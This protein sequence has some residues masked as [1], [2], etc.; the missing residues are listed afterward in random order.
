MLGTRENPFL[1]CEARLCMKMARLLTVLLL[2]ATASSLSVALTKTTTTIASSQNPSIYEQPVTFTA[3]VSPVPPNGE[4]VTFKQGANVLGTGPLSSGSATFTISTLTTGGTDNITAVYGGDSTYATSTSTAVKQVVDPIPTSTSVAS[5]L[6]PSTYGQAV[7]FT[8]SVSS[9]GSGTITG[10]VGFYNGS[11]S[12]GTGAVSGG[13]ASYKTTKLQLPAG[14]DSITAVYKGSTTF[15]TSTSGV[16]SQKVTSTGGAIPTTTTLT[17]SQNPSSYGQTVS[18]TAAVAAGGEPLPASA[19]GDTVTFKQGS[20]TIG[21]GKLSGGSATFMISTLTTGGTDSISAVYGGDSTYAGSTSNT[22][23][24]VVDVAPTTT[25][26]VTSPNPANVG[27]SVTFTAT[28]TSEFGGTPTGNVAFDNGSTV[29]ATVA[30][31]G[32]V[33]SYA[34]TKLAAGSDAITAVYKGSTSFATSTSGTVNQ[35]VGAGTFTYPSMSY[36]G[37]TRYYEVF[38]PSVLPANPAMLLMLHGTRTTPS[39]GSDPTP[40][41]TLNWGWQSYANQ[42]EFILVQ[43]AS[44]FDPVTNQWNWN[45]YCMDGTT[46]CLPYGKKG[47]AFP[48]AEGCSSE[49][50]GGDGECPDD[51]GFLRALIENLTTQYDVNSKA[52]YVTGFSSGAQM[53][54][55]V[56]VE[57]SDLVAAIAPVSGPI[58]NAQGTLTQSQVESELSTLPNALKPISV[59]EWQ[60]TEDENLWPCG[61]GTT[62]YSSVIFTVSSVDDTFNYWKQQNQCTTVETSATLCLN[63]SPNSANDYPSPDIPGD[64]G[65]LATGCVVPPG[66]QNIQV[67]FVWEPGVAHTWNQNNIPYIWNFLSGQQK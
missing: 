32:G 15:A 12:L 61:Y 63:G 37:I 33:A 60:G 52:I 20:N 30:L 65:N 44:T 43:P 53:T 31:S 67:Q 34:T 18:F 4:T 5:S 23:K 24:Q 55:R 54:E 11:T 7:T 51:S 39:T 35:S 58:Y 42:Y 26:L 9:G 8:A 14:T 41:I 10:N 3:V 25:A 38:V 48:Y 1:Q 28:V 13:Q 49:S 21:T 47:G 19:N 59:M 50:G 40:V 6:N 16:L 45:A 64:T 57:I 56:G 66:G 36:G 2:L 22:V 62:S 46:L 17:S 29:L 27:Q